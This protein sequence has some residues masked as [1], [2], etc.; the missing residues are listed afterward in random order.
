M[1]HQLHTFSEGF[2]SL[3]TYLVSQA[4]LPVTIHS[5]QMLPA[6]HFTARHILLRV[7]NVGEQRLL[8]G[9]LV[10]QKATTLLL[11]TTVKLP[12]L[13]ARGRPL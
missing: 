4:L 6:Q 8:R 11:L 2:C 5:Q 9:S 7:F 1:R 10:Q 13:R 3:L 12:K